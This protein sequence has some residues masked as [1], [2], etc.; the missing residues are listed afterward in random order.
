MKII[1]VIGDSKKNYSS[2]SKGLGVWLAKQNVHLLTGGGQGVMA[3]VSQAFHKVS[4]RKGLV[5]G[6][7]PQGS[8]K[9]YSPK[10]GYPNKWVEIPI[11]THLHGKKGSKGAG[12]SAPKGS[13]S[14]NHINALTVAA[15]VA[16]PGGAGTY[17][18]MELAVKYC[19]PLVVYLGAKDTINGLS[20]SALKKKKFNVV[21]TLPAVQTFLLPY[22][23]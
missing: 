3:E 4:L 13:F 11:Y 1:G 16:L 7:I 14:R 19:K 15:M 21:T 6:V 22:C 18:E 10:S 20:I 17:A 5:L 9:P 23:L 8:S 12:V 2:L